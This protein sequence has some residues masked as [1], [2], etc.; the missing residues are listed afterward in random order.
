MDQQTSPEAD[1]GAE[2][3][4]VC[5]RC[6]TTAEAT[7]PTWICSVEN[8]TRHYFCDGCARANLRAIESRLD[9]AWW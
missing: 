7:P 2:S 9:S 1:P 8:H 6:G 5:S 4:A 3:V